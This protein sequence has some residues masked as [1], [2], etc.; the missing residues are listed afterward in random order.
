MIGGKEKQKDINYN[1]QEPYKDRKEIKMP[2]IS[3]SFS[4][5]VGDVEVNSVTDSNGK[6]VD[7]SRLSAQNLTKKLKDGKYFISLGDYLYEGKNSEIE[8]FDFS[9]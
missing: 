2:K 3:F 4:G 7:V 6:K 1:R 5:W 9:N 8:I